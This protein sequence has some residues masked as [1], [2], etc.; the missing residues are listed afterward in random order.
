MIEDQVAKA[1]PQ[2]R[3]VLIV[4]HGYLLYE[5]YW[6]GLDQ[7]DGHEVRSVTKSVIG[8]LVGIAIA[9][10]KIKGL[11]QTVGELLAAQLPKDADPR[12]AGVTVKQLLTMTSGLAG[13]EESLGGDPRVNEATLKSPDWVRH[14]LSRRLETGSQAPTLPI[15]TMALTCCRRSWPTCRANPPWR[16]PA[17]NCS[18]RSESRPTGHLSR[19]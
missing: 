17:P 5:R 3:S 10:G 11:D 18:I 16:S 8:A 19:C 1:Y 15:A 9:E 12:F 13:D 6:Q 7:T 4:R 14:I 2:V